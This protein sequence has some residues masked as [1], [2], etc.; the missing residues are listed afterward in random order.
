MFFGCGC[1]AHSGMEGLVLVD[2]SKSSDLDKLY[3]ARV[4]GGENVGM[5]LWQKI[6]AEG[7]NPM[8]FFVL[9]F[10]QC[11]EEPEMYTEA[12]IC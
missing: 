2:D 5:V 1:V 3:S 12:A 8:L 4:G 11:Q 7:Q 10:A 6:A 9:M